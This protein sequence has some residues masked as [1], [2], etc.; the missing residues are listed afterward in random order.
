L[1]RLLLCAVKEKE[2]EWRLGSWIRKRKR[3]KT[4]GPLGEGSNRPCR[5]ELTAASNF[6]IAL[7]ILAGAAVLNYCFFFF[8]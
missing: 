5:G 1:L 7:N 2:N 8:I 6:N 4:W 3:E